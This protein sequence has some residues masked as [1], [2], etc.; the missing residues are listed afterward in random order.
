MIECPICFE[1]IVPKTKKLL[2]CNHTFCKDCYN[3]Y[4][5]TCYLNNRPTVEC[6][7]CRYIVIDIHE[8]EKRTN[9]IAYFSF[10]FIFVFVPYMFYEFLIILQN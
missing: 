1:E 4:T 7:L 10:L 6:P 9:I 5:E 3:K 2:P 8:D